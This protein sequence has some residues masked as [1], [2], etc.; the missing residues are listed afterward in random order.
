M[1]VFEKYDVMASGVPA[2]ISIKET[3]DFV[4]LYSIDFPEIGV[5]TEKILE[6]ARVDLIKET[7]LK[8]R[9]ILD[10]RIAQ[11]IKKQFTVKAYNIIEKYYR[12][13]CMNNVNPLYD[14][15][16]HQNRVYDAMHQIYK[17]QHRTHNSYI[18]Q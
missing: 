15:L 16:L 18:S 7:K 9:D 10:P 17:I 6:Q 5:G 2:T 1:K 11:N 14:E 12:D 13:R 3:K 4:P 8:A